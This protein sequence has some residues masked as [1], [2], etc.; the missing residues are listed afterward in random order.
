MTDH[1][2]S[3]EYLNAF[4]DNQLDGAERIKIFNTIQQDD[5]LRERVCEISGVKEM[6]QFAYPLQRPAAQ[7]NFNRNFHLNKSL[8]ALAAS[9]LLLLG[10]ASG[11]MAHS[12]SVPS[13]IPGVQEL[14][15]QHLENENPTDTRKIVVHIGNSNSIRVKAALDETESLLASYKQQ[16]H[17]LQ[18][19]LVANKKGVDLYRAN[20]TKYAKRIED[21][22]KKYPNLKLIACGVSLQKLR[23]KGETIQL[24]PHVDIAS[25]AAN[26]INKRL[27]QGWGY[28]RI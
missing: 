10:G 6:L 24:I 2:I 19:E 5:Q 15:Q 27:E 21:L 28:T 23:D 11:W 20:T 16:Q 1:H 13:A 4:V 7:E 8:Q 17:P 9:V 3:D 26:Q 14:T 18:V 22:H 25:S 12:W